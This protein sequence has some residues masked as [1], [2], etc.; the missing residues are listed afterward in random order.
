[1]TNAAFE[2]ISLE[3]GTAAWLAWRHDGI[4]ASE[5]DAILGRNRWKSAAS[6]LAEKSAPARPSSF[7]NAAMERGTALEPQARRHYQQRTGHQVEPACLQNTAHA[8][9]RASV[10]GIC[11]TSARLVEIKCG[12]KVYAHCARHSQVPDYYVGQ[13]QHILAVTGYA[14]IDFWCYLPDA[15]P[16][17]IEVK[18]DETFIR[19]MIAALAR[20]WRQVEANRA[21]MPHRTGA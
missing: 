6:V 14:A 15:P 17:L 7:T 12:E 5:T 16:Q 10:D 20:F 13:L 11:S 3:Q 4:G 19:E 8:F 1:M 2:L 9:L 18:R 21:Q